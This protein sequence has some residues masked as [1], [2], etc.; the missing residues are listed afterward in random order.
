M[1]RQL[2]SRRHTTT[3]P[4]CPHQC[5]ATPP[6]LLASHPEILILNLMLQV[7]QNFFESGLCI[8]S[9]CLSKN[10]HHLAKLYCHDFPRRHTTHHSHRRHSHSWR[11]D[12]LTKPNQADA[13]TSA[14]NL[15]NGK[16]QNQVTIA[17]NALKTKI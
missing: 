15:N 2:H 10:K 16:S 11:H 7:T 4:P 12:D 14:V 9:A 17:F 8:G 1:S 6:L 13:N 5:P 3:Q